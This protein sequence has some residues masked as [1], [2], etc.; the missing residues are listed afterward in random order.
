MDW[1]KFI[2]IIS[3]NA[4]LNYK[5]HLVI[6]VPPQFPDGGKDSQADYQGSGVFRRR[7]YKITRKAPLSPLQKG[8]ESQSHTHHSLQ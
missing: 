6:P 3:R 2:L 8:A 7:T 5:H 4:A 1:Q